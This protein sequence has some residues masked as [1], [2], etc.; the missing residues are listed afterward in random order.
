MPLY[1]ARSRALVFCLVSDPALPPLRVFRCLYYLSRGELVV[2]FQHLFRDVRDV[3][4]V[5]ACPVVPLCSSF[6][7]FPFVCVAAVQCGLPYIRFLVWLM[8]CSFSRVQVVFPVRGCVIPDSL[9][10]TLLIVNTVHKLSVS[11]FILVLI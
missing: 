10:Q 5:T 1:K 11:R 2:T 4:L 8:V 3:C 7:L 6:F 9:F